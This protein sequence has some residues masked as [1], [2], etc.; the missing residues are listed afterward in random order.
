MSMF[1]KNGFFATSINDLVSGTG[2]SRGGIYSD[3]GDKEELFIACLN[4]YRDRLANPAI[5]L[6]TGDTE[7]MTAIGQYFDY[8]INLHAK[9]G[10]PGPGCF[11]ANTMTEVA[12]HHPRVLEAVS[13]HSADLHAA[14]LCAL[15]R[16][17]KSAG[18]TISAAA[19]DDVAHF[20]ATSSQGLWS[21]GRTSTD[22]GDLKRFKDEILKMLAARLRAPGLLSHDDPV[23]NFQAP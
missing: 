2:V 7:G 13:R 12:P 5:E 3:F 1:W 4:S 9:H 17:A 23:G 18:S 11:I 22:L 19:L 16:A 6:L 8:F 10:M 15:T 21:Y 20:L 14:F